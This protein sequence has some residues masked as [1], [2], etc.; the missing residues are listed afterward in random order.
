M[1]HDAVLYEVP[2]NV[3]VLSGLIGH[4]AELA[5]DVLVLWE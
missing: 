3:N 5:V 2:A 4:D 1:M